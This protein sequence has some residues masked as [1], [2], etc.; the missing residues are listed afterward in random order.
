MSASEK[1]NLQSS[2]VIGKLFDLT[3]RRVQQLAKEGI[4]PAASVKPYRFDLLI[5][6]KSYIKYLSDKANGKETKTADTLKA[7]S[8]KLKAEAELKQTKAKISS[9]QLKE[10]EGKMHRSEDVEAVMNDLVYT[11]RSMII[12][13][14]G[15]LAMDVMQATNANE[16]SVII[17][18]ECNKILEDLANYQYDPETYRRR[19][20][21]REGWG[22]I[23]VDET[24]D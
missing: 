20:R 13:L 19:V 11:V 22:D 16:A 1:Q 8:N 10:L 14:P 6:V 9:M 17:R 2:A 23:I 4:L 24:D 15:R 12:A 5:T 3:E 21:D 7:E 18:T